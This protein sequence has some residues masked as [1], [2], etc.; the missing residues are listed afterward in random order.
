MDFVYVIVCFY[1]AVTY[2]PAKNT[3]TVGGVLAVVSVMLFPIGVQTILKYYD[4]N[5]VTFPGI[6][7][8]TGLILY[9]ALALY[10]IRF[11][12][13]TM[14]LYFGFY[15]LQF[16][17]TIGILGPNWSQ[18]FF[19]YITLGNGLVMLSSSLK[20][21]SNPSWG[22]DYSWWGYIFSS[23]LIGGPVNTIL[24][25]NGCMPF[26]FNGLLYLLFNGAFMLMSVK[27]NVNIF[28]I[29]GAL[30]TFSYLSYLS[31]TYFAGSYLFPII[32]SLIGFLIIKIAIYISN[33]SGAIAQSKIEMESTKVENE[34]EYFEEQEQFIP[35]QQQQQP[36]PQ[37][38]FVYYPYFGVNSSN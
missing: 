32:L 33:V 30:G 11:P 35:M 8:E 18:F 6:Y 26:F 7:G 19:K 27:L 17:V 20:I 16:T 34:Q 38:V 5:S 28:L 31:Y 15:F 23:C 13:L 14:P 3:Q 25:N 22:S 10:K 21:S 1:L 37:Q 4:L 36:Q 29:W 2:W 12:F 9:A 24:W